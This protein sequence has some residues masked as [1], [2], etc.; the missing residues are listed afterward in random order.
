M[1]ARGTVPLTALPALVMSETAKVG[2]FVRRDFLIMASYRLAFLSDWAALL[3][4]IVTFHFIGKL[5][6][7]SSVPT[8]GGSG[9]TYVEYVSIGIALTSFMA[10]ALTQVLTAMRT[11]QLMGTLELLMVSPTSSFVVQLGSAV[12]QAVY[13]PIRTA[14]FLGLVAL[15]FGATFSLAGIA[16]S[17]LVLVGFIPVVWGLGLISA[18]G[19][20]TL[21]RGGGVVGIATTAL[22]VG[23]GAYFPATL[24]PSWLQPVIS[25]NPVWVALEAIRGQLL[26]DAGLAEALSAFARLVPMSAITLGLGVFAFRLALR[27]ESRNGT[28]GVY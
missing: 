20:L 28:L 27:R 7:A 24:L 4:Q 13:V 10:V 3:V 23:S 8:Y 21:R 19:T 11:E 17:L 26:G 9:T 14:V 6:S 12:F 16:P 5:V 15:A 2:A 18:A 22:T 1:G 25:F